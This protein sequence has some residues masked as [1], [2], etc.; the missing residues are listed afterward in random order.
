VQR[1]DDEIIRL[2]CQHVVRLLE[3]KPP[4]PKRVLWRWGPPEASRA[5]QWIVRHEKGHAWIAAAPRSIPGKGKRAFFEGTLDD[6]L[7]CVPDT[8]FAAAADVALR[9]DASM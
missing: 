2:E 3:P 4:E 8:L 7:S 1:L 9:R 6:A 5:E